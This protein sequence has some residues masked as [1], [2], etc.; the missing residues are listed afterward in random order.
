MNRLPSLEARPWGEKSGL[1]K[2][3]ANGLE[4]QRGPDFKTVNIQDLI[5]DL[6]V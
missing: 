4:A 2:A 3:V 5:D 1:V 6:R